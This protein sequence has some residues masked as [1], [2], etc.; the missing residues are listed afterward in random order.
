MGA[1]LGFGSAFGQDYL[2]LGLGGGYYFVSG[3]EAGLDPETWL[4]NSPNLTKI[5]PQIRYVFHKLPKIKPYVG[6]FYRHAFVEGFE[7]LD[8]LGYRLGVFYRQGKSYLGVGLAHVF[9]TG[10][11][12]TVTPSCNDVYPEFSISIAI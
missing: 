1:Y 9:F 10:C 7:D 12:K 5:S 2:I 3:L 4:L 6:G 11:D 8:S